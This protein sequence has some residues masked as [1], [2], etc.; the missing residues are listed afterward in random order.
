MLSK[1]I[2]NSA[3]IAVI[4]IDDSSNAVPV[5]EALLKG[6]IK[7]VE[8][9]LRS[10]SA[11]DSLRLI[12]AQDPDIVVGVGTVLT[13]EQLE[14]I[15]SMGAEFGVAPGL[16]AQ[17]IRHAKKLNFPFAPGIVT[18]SDIELGLGLGC[19]TF[20]FFPAEPSGGLKYFKSMTAPYSYL[21]LQY[22][23]LGGLNEHNFKSY[24]LEESILAIGGS[25]IATRQLIKNRDW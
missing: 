20:K 10:E 17:I 13:V 19:K 18:P 16:N 14:T 24:L 7:V 6:G 9:T 23:P 12:K 21:K 4:T 25:W 11:I 22:I 8:L 1:Q 15:V 5:A 3:I 2:K